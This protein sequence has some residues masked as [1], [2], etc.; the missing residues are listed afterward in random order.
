MGLEPIFLALR[1]RCHIQLGDEGIWY[2]RKESNPRLNVRSVTCLV[3]YTTGAFCAS[4]ETRTRNGLSPTP[5][6]KSQLR[7][8]LRQGRFL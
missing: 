7:Y 4:Y 3:H 5:L 8:Q 2:S 6:I 1:V